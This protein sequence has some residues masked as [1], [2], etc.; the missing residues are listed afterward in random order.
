MIVEVVISD[1][2][3]KE[4]YGLILG[5][6]GISVEIFLW[7]V[8]IADFFKKQTDVLLRKALKKMGLDSWREGSCLLAY[9]RHGCGMNALHY[10]CFNEKDAA[11]TSL[12]QTHHFTPSG[13][14]YLAPQPGC[15]LAS[16]KMNLTGERVWKQRRD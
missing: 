13:S 11:S 3:V 9:G 12:V 5:V 7:R 2:K 15:L 10:K 16:R 8:L 6:P 14:S 1:E 4:E